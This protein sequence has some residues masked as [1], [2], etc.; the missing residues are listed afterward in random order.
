MPVRSI[1]PFLLSVRLAAA[2][3]P[4]SE[5]P[6]A[7]GIQD[8]SFLVEEAYNQEPGVIQHI[9]NI[10][11]FFTGHHKEVP[12]SFTQEW[13][14]FSQTHQFSYSVPY[15]FIENGEVGFED[16]RLNYRFQALREDGRTPA[17]APRFTLIV[18]TGQA[19]KGFGRGRVGYEVNLPLS[20]IVSERWTIH[21]N[22]GGSIFP[23][24]QGHHLINSNL[25]GSAIY[26]A[27]RELNFLVESIA[28]WEEDV[29]S[30]RKLEHSLTALLSP[31]ARY[32]FNLRNDSQIVVGLAFPI[33]LTSDS[34]S[35]GTFFYFS[36]EH[37]FVRRKR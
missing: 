17:F 37:A 26:A 30:G 9:W 15:T 25:G 35:W 10:P 18:P 16:V 1:I 34:A 12:A 21:F 22:S 36:F 14:V 23:D 20:K 2:T 19:D 31:G 6:L 5:E 11:L 24:V 7:K 13:P 3:T 4:D 8:N 28:L 33:G 32:A 27:T 29:G